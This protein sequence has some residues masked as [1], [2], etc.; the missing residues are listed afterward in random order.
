[1]KLSKS[2]AHYVKA[3]YKLSSACDGARVCDIAEE[4]CLSKASVSLAMT[5]LTKQGLVSKD[6][7]HHIHLTKD[8][9]REAMRLLDKFEMIR[10]FLIGL[11]V[12]K[13]VAEHDACAMEHVVSVDTLCAICRSSG[14]W[15]KGNGCVDNCPIPLETETN[16][17]NSAT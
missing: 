14:F 6:A 9:E 2:Q 15:E 12:D 10:Q 8:G 11:G 13:E 4:L 16:Y 3:V 17:R 1:M 7:E 5:R